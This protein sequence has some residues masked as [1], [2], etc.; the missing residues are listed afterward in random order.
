[1]NLSHTIKFTDKGEIRVSARHDREQAKMAFGVAD[2]GIGIPPE[3]LPF[4]FDKFWQVE[5]AR[6]RTQ[7]G[8]GMGTLYR[9]RF[10]RTAWRES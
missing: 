3:E 8:I 4:V 10:Y 7:S 6:T 1:M 5:S 9:A 2:T